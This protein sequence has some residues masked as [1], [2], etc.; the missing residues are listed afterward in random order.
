MHIFRFLTI[1]G[2]GALEFKAAIPAGLAMRLD[3]FATSAAATL[4]AT[5]DTVVILLLGENIRRLIIA[6]HGP[7]SGSTRFG[8]L[9]RAYSRFGPA[10]LGLVAPLLVGT[11][12][13]TALGI[14]LG[15]KPRSLLG[16]MVTGTAFWSA[17][18]TAAAVGGISGWRFFF[19]L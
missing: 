14:S 4:G 17:V 1:V 11:P 19:H 3:P 5:L 12:I 6:K 16:W 9:E 2:L 18:L 15:M 10:G 13:G 8:W 7:A